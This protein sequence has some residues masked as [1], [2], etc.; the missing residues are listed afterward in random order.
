[1]DVRPH[2]HINLATVTNLFD[3]EIVH[4]DSLGSEQPITPGA[5]NWM[6]AG[7]GI[8]HSERVS[9]D[10]RRRGGRM[11]GI[12]TWVALPAEHEE[13]EPAFHHHPA[14]TLPVDVVGGARVQV[15]VGEGWGLRSPVAPLSPCF[16]ADVA[17]EVGATLD[18]P[19]YEERAAYVLSGTIAVGD[20]AFGPHRL[21]VLAGDA[22]LEAREAAHVVLLG[23]STLGDRHIWW[24][25]VSTRKDRIEAAGRQW[26]ERR[27]P[28][29]PGDD[30]EFIPLPD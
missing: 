24:N 18:V 8:V 20:Q 26:R 27:F 28:P 25:F 7:R 29:I 17:L 16:Y 6:T 21:V 1:M 23:G 15:L 10:R 13:A 11:H 2:P 12:Q 22:V 30:T 9:P 3:G 5:V 19:P 4:R 14:D